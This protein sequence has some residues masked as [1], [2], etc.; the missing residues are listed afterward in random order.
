VCRF[1]VPRK[2][3]RS[4]RKTRQR[5]DQKLFDTEADHEVFLKVRPKVTEEGPQELHLQGK[6]KT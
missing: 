1:F 6:R 3:H 2:A 4:K 5:K